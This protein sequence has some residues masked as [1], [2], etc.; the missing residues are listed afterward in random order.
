MSDRKF[1]KQVREVGT[2]KR[3]WPNLRITSF[4]PKAANLND[5]CKLWLCRYL[6]AIGSIRYSNNFGGVL[7]LRK[8]VRAYTH[9]LTQ[10]HTHTYIYKVK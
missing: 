3:T 9:R 7:I 4:E 1:Y 6:S 2:R 8:K 5:H 10:T